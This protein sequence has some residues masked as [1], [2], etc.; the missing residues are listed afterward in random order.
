MP[1]IE[2]AVHDNAVAALESQREAYGRYLE[3]VNAQHKAVENG[4][5]RLMNGLADQLDTIIVEIE[6]NGNDLLPV[7][8]LISEGK[9]DGPRVQ[10]IRDLMTAVTA[11]AAM[12]QAR[13]RS[14]THTLLKGRDDTR[15]ELE[16]L[17]RSRQI[18]ISRSRYDTRP[19]NLVD[20]RS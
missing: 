2:S 1:D 16:S 5:V 10:V 12:A 19:P 9:V 6:E 13:V 14:L 18:E 11:D 20:A 15:R 17:D 4:N 3:I 8:R 7:Y